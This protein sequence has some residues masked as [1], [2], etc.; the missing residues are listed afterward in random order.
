MPQTL[1]F[2]DEILLYGYDYTFADV[3]LFMDGTVNFAGLDPVF[4]D[5]VVFRIAVIPADFAKQVD[6]GK[7]EDV[8]QALDMDEV[9]ILR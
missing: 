1:F 5:G 4:T 9:E 3:R 8:L 6:T 2:G 7:L